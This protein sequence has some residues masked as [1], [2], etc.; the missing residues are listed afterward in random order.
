MKDSLNGRL[1]VQL[2]SSKPLGAI[3]LWLCK[4][5]IRKNTTPL[6]TMPPG[7]SERFLKYQVDLEAL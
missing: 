3:S 4:K 5:K 7:R 6:S 1:A 2:I